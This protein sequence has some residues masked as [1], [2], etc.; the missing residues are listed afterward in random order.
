MW[1]ID[2]LFAYWLNKL[3]EA[4]WCFAGGREQLNQLT[5]YIDASMIYGS[6]KEEAIAL[7]ELT[8][9]VFSQSVA[10]D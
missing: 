4:D 10:H 3:N 1:F 7:R 9:G 2:N 8:R 6:T 5:S